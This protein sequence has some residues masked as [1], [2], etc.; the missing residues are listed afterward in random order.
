M[1]HTGVE[2]RDLETLAWGL[3]LTWCGTWWGILEPGQSLPAGTGA[4]GIGLIL[5]GINAARAL[6]GIPVYLFSSTFGLLFLIWGGLKLA[7]LYL[8]VPPFELS[9]CGLFLIVLG[10][11]VLMREVLK[12]RKTGI[13]A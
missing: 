12:T 7:R 5:L 6:K 13:N 1:N 4:V 8:H 11:S 3:L 2:K 9:V 10:T